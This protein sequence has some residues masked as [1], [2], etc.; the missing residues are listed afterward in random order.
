ML[1]GWSLS[2]E[3]ISLADAVMVKVVVSSQYRW[4]SNLPAR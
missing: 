2:L 4:F 1:V 3:V